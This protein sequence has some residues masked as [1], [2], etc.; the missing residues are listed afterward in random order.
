MIDTERPG[1][2]ALAEKLDLPPV[3]WP[4]P[5][6]DEVSRPRSLDRHIARARA[7]MGEQRWSELNA[8]WNSHD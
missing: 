6:T 3:K 8:E 7:E 2:N 5:I 4:G 1:F